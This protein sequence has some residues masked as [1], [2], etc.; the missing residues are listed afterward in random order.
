MSEDRSA[1]MRTDLSV[2]WGHL[3]ATGIPDQS[4]FRGAV[5][6]TPL[7]GHFGRTWEEPVL[8]GNS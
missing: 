5:V 3:K 4:S 1:G 7:C 8:S 6:G 2:V